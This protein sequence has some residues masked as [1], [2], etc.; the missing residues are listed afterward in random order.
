[1]TNIKSG[2]VPPLPGMRSSVVET[3]EADLDW[4]ATFED[5]LTMAIA[6]RDWEQAVKLVKRGQSRYTGERE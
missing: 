6:V 4:L 2:D 3:D 1:M 5:D